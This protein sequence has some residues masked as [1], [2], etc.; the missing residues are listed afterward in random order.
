MLVRCTSILI[1]EIGL[2]KDDIVDSTL[3]ESE[4]GEW[5]ANLFFFQRK[6]CL[7]FTNARTLFTF[8]SFGVNRTQI[9]NLGDLFHEGLARIPE[10]RGH[11][12]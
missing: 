2:S 3:Q 11:I 10:F 8:M 1:K 4:L 6:K 12:T 7:I 9:R 5:Y